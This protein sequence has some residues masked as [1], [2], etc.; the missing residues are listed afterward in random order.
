[1]FFTC[2]SMIPNCPQKT[3]VLGQDTSEAL[4]SFDQIA[5]RALKQEDLPTLSKQNS[6]RACGVHINNR[7]AIEYSYIIYIYI[8]HI[9]KL[10]AIEFSY[11]YNNKLYIEFTDGVHSNDRLAKPFQKSSM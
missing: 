1:M 9:Y 2:Q 6:E 4:L 8:W 5:V 7:F 3:L 11:T 10:Y